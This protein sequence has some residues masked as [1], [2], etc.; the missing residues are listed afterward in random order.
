[1]APDGQGWF[2]L[3]ITGLTGVLAVMWTVAATL[4]WKLWKTLATREW[5]IIQL[6]SEREADIER[7]RRLIADL[8]APMQ[9]EIGSI[10][11]EITVYHAENR[12]RLNEILNLLQG[13][14]RP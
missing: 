1:M 3:V 6:S 4:Y 5:V 14:K 8:L 11:G 12:D 7:D 9:L 10:K 2:D 13:R